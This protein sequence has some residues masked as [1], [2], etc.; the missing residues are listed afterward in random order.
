M[1]N[2]LTCRLWLVVIVLGFVSMLLMLGGCTTYNVYF[3]DGSFRVAD[4][5]TVR[6][7]PGQ[8][9]DDSSGQT[10]ETAGGSEGSPGGSNINRGFANQQN[11]IQLG[12]ATKPT[13][14]A[15]ASA[16]VNSP[17]SQTGT[18]GESGATGSTPTVG[19]TP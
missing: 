13:T 3:E 10:G 15:K 16:T 6:T 8:G 2:V 7:Q 17:N 1:R 4:E 9:G 14:D 19:G 11:L 12:A 5:L 18:G